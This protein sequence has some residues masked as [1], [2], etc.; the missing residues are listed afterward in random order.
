[1]GYGKVQSV[2]TERSKQQDGGTDE[3]VR[4]K[5]RRAD[6]RRVTMGVLK[7]VVFPLIPP[8][9]Y[10]CPIVEIQVSSDTQQVA[11]PPRWHSGSCQQFDQPLGIVRF[12]QRTAP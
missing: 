11:L 7:L 1:M 10:A 6:R 2:R 5:K 4:P 9:D 3:V 8:K 12:D